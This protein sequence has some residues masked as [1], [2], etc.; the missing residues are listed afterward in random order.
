MGDFVKG[1]DY[2]NYPIE[3]KN[4]ILLHR[5]IDSFTDAHPIVLKS[6]KRLHT[7]YGHY[8]GIVVDIFY[9]HFLAKNWDSA[10][11]NIGAKGHINSE[12][13][14]EYWDEGQAVLN[15]LLK[16]IKERENRKQK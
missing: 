6:K 16:I 2:E 4:G 15:S 5:Q 12:S 3:I 10:F 1:S 13:K 11:V 14:L 9:D 8:S 7:H